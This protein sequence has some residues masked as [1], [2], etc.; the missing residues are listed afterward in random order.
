MLDPQDPNVQSATFGRMVEDFFSSPIGEYFIEQAEK[1]LEVAVEALKI[2]DAE[3]PKLI[4]KYQNDAHVA[5]KLL[6]WI[7]DA[8]LKGHMAITNLQEELNGD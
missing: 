2:V 1:E 5:S 7:A 8:I 6:A 3:D 4:R